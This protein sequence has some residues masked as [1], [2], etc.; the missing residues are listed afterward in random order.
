[1]K[2]NKEFCIKKILEAEG[3]YVDH[4]EDPGGCTNKGI[5][6]G[7]LRDWRWSQGDASSVDCTDVRNITE[8]EA[9]AIYVRNYWEPV[10]G[11]DLSPGLDLHVFDMGVNSGPSRAVKLLQEMIGAS[12]DGVI[13]PNT[14]K[15]IG[16]MARSVGVVE[17]IEQYSEKRREYYRSL[18]TFAT[19]GQGW[20]NRVDQKET[21]SIQLYHRWMEKYGTGLQTVE[22][23]QVDPPAEPSLEEEILEELRKLNETS[24][25]ILK[26]VDM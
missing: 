14:R 26:A 3:G 12:A 15:A 16:E 19:F 22:P 4:P 17:M 25:W 24:S 7:T 20:L 18:S 5:T 1:M 23:T 21:E 2:E 9:V 13:G 6:I 11:D 10:D 8:D